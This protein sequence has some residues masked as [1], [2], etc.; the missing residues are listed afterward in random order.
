MTDTDII[1]PLLSL[2]RASKVETIFADSA[3]IYWPS[4]KFSYGTQLGTRG[5]QVAK[6]WP[7]LS[8]GLAITR[9][10]SLKLGL[11]TQHFLAGMG[12]KS[13]VYKN[14]SC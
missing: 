7:P 8:I 14:F 3:L 13:M 2:Y 4:A 12:P 5:Y 9:V 1:G 10:Q 6:L 11:L